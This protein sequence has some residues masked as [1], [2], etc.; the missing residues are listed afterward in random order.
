MRVLTTLGIAAAPSVTR[1]VTW[2]P[3]QM[4]GALVQRGVAR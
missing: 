3:Y 4:A 1:R 2:A